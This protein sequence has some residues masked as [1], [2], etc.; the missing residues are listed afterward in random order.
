MAADVVDGKDSVI[1]RLE[2]PGM[3]RSDFKIELRGETLSIQGEKRIER[4][5]GGDG[6]RTIQCA[7]GSFRRDVPLPTAVNPDKAKATYRDGVLRVVLLSVISQ[8]DGPMIKV[9][10]G[11]RAIETLEM[12]QK[13]A[14]QKEVWRLICH[15]AQIVPRR[16]L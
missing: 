2:A 11:C 10:D 9:G 3:T 15:R 13:T 5:S 12:A 6:H 4:E 16:P 14:W 7:Y 8:F 1:V